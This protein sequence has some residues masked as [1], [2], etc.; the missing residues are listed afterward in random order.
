MKKQKHHA[1]L[2]TEAKEQVKEILDREQYEKEDADQT[3]E[4]FSQL[5][6][7]NLKFLRD[8]KR[9]LEK[10]KTII[11]K[12]L[13]DAKREAEMRLKEA[14][15][16]VKQWERERRRLSKGI[17]ISKKERKTNIG[18]RAYHRFKKI[19]LTKKLAKHLIES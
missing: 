10:T 2:I 7:E 14:E 19:G 6:G 16:G 11:R 9:T 1:E 8:A 17:K 13:K 3:I 4:D 5:L 15:E 18:N 12:I